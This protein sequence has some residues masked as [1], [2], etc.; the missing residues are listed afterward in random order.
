[1]LDF[2]KKWVN[3]FFLLIVLVIILFESKGVGD[4]KIFIDAS[5]DLLLGKNIYQETYNNWYHYYY[6]VLFA[7]FLV[8]LSFL[9]LYFSKLIWLALNV[10]FTYQVFKIIWEWLPIYLL[11]PDKKKVFKFLSFVFVLAF[12]RDNFH[13]SQL[14]IFILFLTLQGLD[15]I[16]GNQKFK[17]SILLALGVTIKILP[18]VFIPYLIYRSEIKSA[19]LVIVLVVF[20][21]FLPILFIGNEYNNYL[22]KE[23]WRIINPANTEHVMD[24]GERSFHSLT[25]LLSTLL[26]KDCGDKLALPVKRNIFDVSIKTLNTVI[27]LVRL[28]LVFGVLYFIRSRPF[29]VASSNSQ[30]FYEISYLCL[31]VPL[32]FPHQQHYAFLFILPATSYM[33]F[34]IIYLHFQK[35]IDN[36]TEAGLY[37]K[38]SI[39]FIMVFVYL[40]TNSH[41]ILGAYNKWYDHFKT[42]TYGALILLVILAFS[43]PKIIESDLSIN[44]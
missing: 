23:R 38:V 43:N 33:L 27:N 42:L 30:S 10:F 37:K 14:T 39:L 34:Y 15:F 20:Y 19:V 12:L 18:I 9:P 7:L 36:Q 25:T 44:K 40:L 17:G 28:V 21:L 11:N 22:L 5:R 24:T 4:F 13:T 8:P 2:F 29:K 32:I 41:F 6:D 35:K 16:R 3:Y 1:M 26:V 31:L